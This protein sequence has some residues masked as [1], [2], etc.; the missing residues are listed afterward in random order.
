MQITNPTLSP[1]PVERIFSLAPRFIFLLFLLAAGVFLSTG[2]TAKIKKARHLSRADKYYNTGQ[3]AKA[4]VEYLNVVQ[5]DSTNAHVLGRLGSIY[6]EEGRPI[7]SYAFLKKASELN[8]NDLDLQL[9]LSNIDLARGNPN[10]AYEK[11]LSV[12][13]KSPT[14]PEAPVLLA[15]SITNQAQAELVRARL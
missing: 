12:L 2:C 9:K 14:N 15:D 4:E 1:A 5:L 10:G 13:S 11:A 6:Y 8:P 3:Y 7:R